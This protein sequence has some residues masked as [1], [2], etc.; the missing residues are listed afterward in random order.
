MDWFRHRRERGRPRHPDVLTPAE[1]RVL[2]H[3]REGATNAEV[4]VRLGLSI[5]TVR[6]HVS[7][8][9]AKL[10]LRDRRELAA[11][12]GEPQEAS[13]VALGRFTL[14]AP[15]AWLREAW[16]G[17][18]AV[19][20]SVVA[21]SVAAVV[22]IS[23]L[24]GAG[25]PATSTPT[26]TPA[27]TETAA[28]EPTPT[29]DGEWLLPFGGVSADPQAPSTPDRAVTIAAPQS[30]F[31]LYDPPPGP[32][33]SMWLYD[34]E[35]GTMTDHGPGY[36]ALFMND[37]RSVVWTRTTA[38]GGDPVVMVLDLQ[39]GE[40]REL[41]RGAVHPYHGPFS[42]REVLIQRG[43][44]RFVVDIHTGEEWPGAALVLPP[45]AFWDDLILE[46]Y[47]E[48]VGQIEWQGLWVA[49]S[50]HGLIEPGAARPLLQFDATRV[51]YAGSGE[52]VLATPAIEEHRRWTSNLYI[53][54][55]DSRAG[56]YVATT[57]VQLQLPLAANERYVAWNE[58]YCNLESDIPRSVRLYDRESDEL[59]EIPTELAVE[60]IDGS[61]LGLSRSGF[62]VDAWLD[63]ETMQWL[64]V[65]P[66]GSIHASWSPDRRYASLGTFGGHGGLCG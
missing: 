10:E 7:S 23:Q 15:F 11:W 14:A 16:V 60:E 37:G 50:R 62:G 24:Q 63:L 53:V 17:K 46:Q 51:G 38:L 26:G 8:M 52:F 9:L 40:E 30:P 59:I 54:D 25:E 6:Y 57:E 35:T 58:R 5:N 3:V 65:M 28:P 36:I 61:L 47:E 13:R 41:V 2:E 21:V 55:I 18:V 19:G 42:S 12:V 44:S 1:W 34:F 39:T 32:G 33:Q 48:V 27:V 20:A 49:I 64:E 43:G 4:A 29:P 66:E 22:V 56:R 31:P 45:A